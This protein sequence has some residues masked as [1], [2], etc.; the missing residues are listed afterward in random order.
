MVRSAQRLELAWIVIFC[1]ASACSGWVALAGDQ[2][3]GSPPAAERAKEILAAT[4]V[5]GGLVVHLGCGDG[6][7]TAAL[8]A[9]SS[10]LVHGLDTDPARVDAARKHIQ[11]LGLYGPVSVDCWAGA[12]LPYVDN[13]VNLVVVEVPDITSQEE[14]MRVLAP[15]GAAYAANVPGW[16]RILR[17][18]RPAEI[19]EWTHYLHDASNNPVAQDEQVGP[20]RHLQ[21]VGSPR[22]SRHH[23]HMASMSA[24]VSSAGRIFYILD[25]GP[26]SSIRLPARWSLIARDAFNGTILWRRPIGL[27]DTHL[28]PLK[29]GPAQL[30]RRLVAVGET[31][32]VTL[33]LDAPISA[34]D[35]ATGH[36]LR[37]YDRTQ[38]AEELIVADGVL[39]CLISDRPTR[40]NDYRQKFTYVWDNTNHANRRWAWDES[41][42]RI[43]AIQADTG[44]VLWTRQSSVAPL[45]LAADR[46]RVYFF[47]GKVVVCLNRADGTELWRSEPVK[48]RTPITT[49][50]GPNLIVHKDVV[51]FSGGDRTMTALS[52]TDG[53]KL[54]TAEHPRSGHASPEDLLVVGGLVWAGAIADSRDSGLFCGRDLHTGEIKVRF[55]P[56]VDIYWFHHRCHRSKATDQYLLTSRTGIEFVDWRARNWQ[57]HHWVRGGCIYGIMPC[58]GLIYAPPHDCACYI[59]SKLYGFNALAGASPS[60]AIRPDTPEEKRLQ[61][62]PAYSA[63]ALETSP[64][65]EAADDWPTYRHD[66]ARSGCTTAAVPVELKRCWQAALGGRLSSPVIAGGKVFVASVDTHTLYALDATSGR[67][68][69]SYTA[70]ARIDSPPT[71]DQ[72]RALFGCADGWIYCL[73]AADGT[74]VW[75]FRAAP[76]ERRLM[77]FEQLESAWPVHGSVLVQSG[78]VHAVAGRSMFLDGG[79]RLVRLDAKTGR[80]LSETVLDDRD[81]QSG[82][83]LQSRVRGLDMPVALPD[84]LSSDGQYLY[85]R[86]QKL[87]TKGVRQEIDP[88]DATEQSGEDAHLFST[89]GFLDDSWFHRSLWLYG[90]TATG[91]YGGWYRPGRF[92]P[93]GR[94]LVFDQTTVY[95][96]GRQ[97]EFWCNNSVLR[98]E[99]F[100]ADKG[101]QEDAVRRVLEATGRMNA[102]S[103]KKSADSSDWALRQRFPRDG[104]T[105]VAYQWVQQSPPV[106]ARALVLAGKTLWMAGPPNILDEQQHFS[107]P[108]DAALEAKAQQQRDALEGKL[109]SLLLAVSAADGRCLA[110]YRLPGLP[111]FDGMAAAKAQLFL[112]TSDGRVICLGAAGREPLEQARTELASLPA[113]QK[114]ERPKPPPGHPDFQRQVGVKVTSGNL[115]YTL[116]PTDERF[117]MALKKL[118]TPLTKTARFRLQMECLAQSSGGTKLQNGFLVFG[119][120]AD[121]GRLIKCGLRVLQGVALVV[122]GPLT[123]GK[124]ASVKLDPGSRTTRFDIEI[125]AD[126]ESRKVTMCAAG[127]TVSLTLDRQLPAIRYVGYGVLGAATS[128]TPVQISGD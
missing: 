20:P 34:L 108:E 80:K 45:T 98:Y 42:Q 16:P 11:S 117:G 126:L 72:G 36:T 102:Q 109:G 104:L 91:G 79:M 3:P 85:M 128:F 64:N 71:I 94:M 35:A 90:R 83:D 33:G 54:W 95:G 27:W 49:S 47:D 66:P 82:K 103:D 51:L 110:G 2:A 7:L 43:A 120:T 55:T 40:R 87:D 38:G 118:Q 37:T 62:G 86:S 22:W 39:F 122:D 59:V 10:Y 81:P 63:V 56:N 58:N 88:R 78:V 111:V 5:R 125:S 28:W 119:D 24:C 74:L 97:P 50:F 116:Q 25:E 9:S 68:L 127:K 69:W 123:R 96:F 13:L 113:P 115:G 121:D 12:R 100:A 75:R 53:K 89:I 112:T 92:A 65:T 52:A 99:Y 31:V 23:D 14:V 41:P 106:L 44:T 4:G 76:D 84:I 60:R 1:L 70:G 101:I 48:R 30:P 29:S 57:T 46:Q 6:R 18:P 107:R 19:D 17:K 77:A 32:F 26:T 15:G 67:T 124:S 105:A 8:R 93:S 61:R 114:L 73:S 21:W